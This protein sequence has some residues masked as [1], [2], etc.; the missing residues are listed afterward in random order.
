MFRAPHI[1]NEF[2]ALPRIE[3]EHLAPLLEGIP[4]SYTQSYDLPTITTGLLVGGIY[5]KKKGLH[6]RDQALQR[7]IFLKVQELNFNISASIDVRIANLHNG[8]DYNSLRRLEADTVGL[9]CIPKHGKSDGSLNDGR[10]ISPYGNSLETWQESLES[11]RPLFAASS[12]LFRR[13]TAEDDELRG[14]IIISNACLPNYTK[15]PP[16]DFCLPDEYCY[17]PSLYIL[18]SIVRNDIAVKLGLH[19]LG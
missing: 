10:L 3:E 18:H 7:K 15:L 1:T 11:R 19:N 6:Y 12:E 13:P 2:Y 14:E 16:E 8:D 17:E 4:L 5:D 9:C